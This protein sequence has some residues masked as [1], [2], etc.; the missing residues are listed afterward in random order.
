M[1]EKLDE[2]ENA[3][4]TKIL[5]GEIRIRTL[6]EEMEA[7]VIGTDEKQEVLF[8]NTGGEEKFLK[9]G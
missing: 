6:I 8:V 9:P 7:G 1:A 3:G 5:S 4:L 2:S